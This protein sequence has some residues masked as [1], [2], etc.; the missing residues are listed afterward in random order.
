MRHRDAVRRTRGGDR[1]RALAI[2]LLCA[3]A[4]SVGAEATRVVPSALWRSQV[5]DIPAL[6]ARGAGAPAVMPVAIAPAAAQRDRSCITM[7]VVPATGAA[8]T[9]LPRTFIRA[10]SDSVWSRFGPWQRGT[11]YRLDRLRGDVRFIRTLAPGETVWVQVCG[12]LSPPPLEYVRQEFRPAPVVAATDSVRPREAPLAA[13]SRPATARDPG[14]APAGAALTVNGNKT[15]AVDFGSSQDA[16]LRQSL[17]LSVSG[18]VAPGVELTGVLSDRDTPLSAAGATQDLQSIDRVLVELK[19]RDGRGA[20]GDIPLSVQRGEFARLERRVQG[21]SGEWSPGAVTL[22]AAAAGAQGEYRR[23]QFQGI[24]GQQGPYLLT[25]RDGA[26]GI[27]VVAGS[28][29]VTVDG[30]RMT[31]GEGADYAID[32]ERA[33]LTFSNRRPISSASRITVEYQYALTRFRRNLSAASSEWR[34]G[35]WSL[36]VQGLSEGDDSGRPLAGAF[37]ADDRS[38]LARAGD[39]LALGPGVSAGGGDYDTVR[40]AGTLRFVFAGLD[41]GEFAVRFARVGAG[42]G[43]YADS[44]VVGGRTI[45]RYVGPLAGVNSIGRALASPETHQ[46]GSAGASVQAGAVRFEAEGALSRFDR[47][48]LSVRDNGDDAGAAGRVKLSLAGTLRGL[49]GRVGADAAWRAI[50]QRFTPFSRLERAF[51]EEDWGLTAGADLEHQRRAESSL[52]WQPGEG[53]ELRGELSRLSTPDGYSGLRRRGDARWTQGAWSARGVLLAADGRTSTRLFADGGRRRANGELRW[54]AGWLAPT[55]RG[56]SDR[57]T[58]PGD[59]ANSVDRARSVD[60]ELASG[61]RLPWRML[62]GSGVRSDVRESGRTR[63]STRARTWRGELETATAAPIGAVVTAQRRDTRDETTGALVRQDLASTRLRAEWVPAG[64]TGSLQVERTGEAENRR[65]RTLR[66]VGAG[67]G[68]YDAT[69]NFVGTGDYDLVLVVSPDLE[70][71]ARTATSARA[72]WRFGSSEAWRGSRVE[73]TLED[74]A[75]RRG[76]GRLSDVFLSTGLALVDGALARGLILQR[77]E[78]E[79][80]PGSRSIAVRARAERRVSADR[81]FENFGQTT[82]QRSGSLRWRARPGNTTSAEAEARVQWQSAVQAFAAGASFTRTLVEQ[83]GNAQW[84]WQPSADLRV[85]SVAEASWSKLQGAF[86]G[87]RT[88]RLGP[89]VGVGVGKAG[90]AELSLRRAFVGGAPALGLL[91]S[92]EAA[93]AARWDGTAR[94][95]YR[96]HETTTFN[97]DAGVRERPGK[98]TV[99]TGRAEVRAFF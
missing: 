18:N 93:G 98:R 79:L 47:N 43:D 80:A 97:L 1:T 69:G 63:A 87:T 56:E 60:A 53:R 46:L 36:F 88:L 67:R 6:A 44:S 38:A 22:R 81:T 95:N 54:H 4:T 32:Y 70:R 45:Q 86:E 28:E 66:F 99:V 68:G 9:R 82:D 24:D 42:R 57:R 75:R 73:F 78:A 17:D 49:P 51:A 71:F 48:T 30:D 10:G 35:A 37:D 64:L 15:I 5:F 89:D 11:D 8:V 83:G 50:D 33:R 16:A 34:R 7:P 41:S 55:V 74:E 76:S 25:D 52:W 61:E 13:A 2:A 29:Q 92:A 21:V 23:M 40:V 19:A 85:A 59:S 65:V 77:L 14:S 91:P 27:T 90:R 39:S 58:V 12:L 62:F 3:G 31:R 20:L 72:A 94:F 96:V 26:L 84:V